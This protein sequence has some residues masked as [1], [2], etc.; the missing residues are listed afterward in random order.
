MEDKLKKQEKKMFII[1]I[2]MQS[3][4][5]LIE[6]YDEKKDPIKIYFLDKMQSILCNQNSELEEEEE[7]PII[8]NKIKFEKKEKRRTLKNTKKEKRKSLVQI[9]KLLKTPKNKK[10][11][12][13]KKTKKS[14][15]V[16]MFE[17]RKNKRIKNTI[18]KNKIQTE[19]N[20]IKNRIED[21]LNSFKDKSDKK[22]KI[23]KEN[24]KNQENEIQKKLKLRRQNSL[25]R[26]KNSFFSNTTKSIFLKNTMNNT[27]NNN[28]LNN[29]KGSFENNISRIDTS[30]EFNNILDSFDI[31]LVSKNVKSIINCEYGLD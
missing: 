25:A 27:M 14:I 13:Q 16:N 8:K 17:I 3:Y 11:E 19:K 4:A 10:K 31:E 6:F 23:I 30:K 18:L 7:K 2:L 1:P 20:S 22:T 21:N 5:K 9:D 24:L 28:K 12:K 26:S 15:E 29:L